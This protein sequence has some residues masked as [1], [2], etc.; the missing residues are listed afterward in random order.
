MSIP[1]LTD[2]MV[3]SSSRIGIAVR[4]LAGPRSRSRAAEVRAEP[5]RRSLSRARS[6]AEF[7]HCRDPSR[8]PPTW[9]P[10]RWEGLLELV[11]PLYRAQ[12]QIKVTFKILPWRE[13]L[14]DLI[15]RLGELNKVP[16]GHFEG[17]HT[18][19]WPLAPAPPGKAEASREILGLKDQRGRL[20]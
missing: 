13:S 16:H 1:C 15:P 20:A 4:Q 11:Q 8:D 9:Q 7:P 19:V 12:Q 3:Q 17:L 14:A 18:Q 5:R 2:F 10:L 6:S